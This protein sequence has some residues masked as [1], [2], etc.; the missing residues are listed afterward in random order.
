MAALTVAELT[1]A[2]VADSLA[3]AAGGGDTF[4]NTGSEWFEINN[5]GGSP[6]TVTFAAA[7][8]Y[9]GETITNR[10]VTVAN[11][12]RKKIGR[13]PPAIFGTTV[14]VTYSAVTSVTVGVFK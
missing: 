9:L 8:T 6:I 1:T 2:G 12:A 3:A 13:F 7:S 14:T 5:G 4:A 10:A 11:G